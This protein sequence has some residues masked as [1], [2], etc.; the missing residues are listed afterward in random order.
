MLSSMRVLAQDRAEELQAEFRIAGSTS[1]VLR[2]L[3]CMRHAGLGMG[4]RTNYD[5]TSD[6]KPL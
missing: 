4:E 5:G 1:S 2:E 6:C 3:L